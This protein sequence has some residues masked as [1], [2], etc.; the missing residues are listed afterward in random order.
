[1]FNIVL[2]EPE[3]PSNTGNIGRT[4]VVTNSRLHLVGRLGFNLSE[5]AVARS[6]MDYWNKVSYK[7]YLNYREFMEEMKEKNPKARIWYA[8]TKAK[9]GGNFGG[10]RRKLHSDPDG[11]RGTVT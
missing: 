3:I 6:G 8:T 9:P 11:K 2:L 1:M 7:R 10:T 5:K 4:C